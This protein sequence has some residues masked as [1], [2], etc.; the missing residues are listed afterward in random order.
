MPADC[1][2]F[3]SFVQRPVWPAPAAR[4]PSADPL[5]KMST[6]QELSAVVVRV[7]EAAP[8]VLKAALDALGADWATL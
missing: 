7:V 5:P 2:L 6:T 1:L 4:F 3:E 8:D